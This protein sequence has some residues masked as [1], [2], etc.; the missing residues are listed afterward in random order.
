MYNVLY[1]IQGIIY[2]YII[3][4]CHIYFSEILHTKYINIQKKICRLK[5]PLF[6]KHCF[7]VFKSRKISKEKQ[8]A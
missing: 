6:G 7:E 5:T 4:T 8:E 1:T 3:F 2:L